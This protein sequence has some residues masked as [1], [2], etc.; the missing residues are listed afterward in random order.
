MKTI[1]VCVGFPHVWATPRLKAA[2]P[3]KCSQRN[4]VEI[5]LPTLLRLPGLKCNGCNSLMNPVVFDAL[6]TIAEQ[7][8]QD[9]KR[10]VESN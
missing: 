2:F 10:I 5:E 9:Q 1:D 6:K 8:K 4:E 7:F 3:C